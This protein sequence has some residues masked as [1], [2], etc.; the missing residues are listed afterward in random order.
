VTFLGED[1]TSSLGEVFP[2]GELPWDEDAL[3]ES[4]FR[5]IAV[6]KLFKKLDGR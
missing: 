3:A 2:T 1:C 4:K 6:E 5:F